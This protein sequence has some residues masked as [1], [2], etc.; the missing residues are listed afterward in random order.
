MPIMLGAARY[1]VYGNVE[2]Q[3]IAVWQGQR[4]MLWQARYARC[5]CY[6]KDGPAILVMPRAA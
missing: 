4:P 6:A 1:A 5:A 2:M 3:Q